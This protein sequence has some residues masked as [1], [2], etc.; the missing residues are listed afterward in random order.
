[1]W[2]GEEDVGTEK[3]TCQGFEAG[4]CLM[5]LRKCIETRAARTKHELQNFQVADHG[6]FCGT[7]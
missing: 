7:L 4:G 2:M 5:C 1:M 6:R 3:G